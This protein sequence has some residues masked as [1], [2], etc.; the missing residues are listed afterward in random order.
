[1]VS[2]EA[3]ISLLSYLSPCITLSFLSFLLFNPVFVSLSFFH[4]QSLVF[5][6]CCCCC[7]LS[8]SLCFF[9]LSHSHI[10][11]LP[12]PPP[13]AHF[14]HPPIS[15]FFSLFLVE[16]TGRQRQKQAVPGRNVDRRLCR[17]DVWKVN[18]HRHLNPLNQHL[19]VLS[20]FSLQLPSCC[21]FSTV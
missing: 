7:R 21:W 14:L 6:C 11:P 20:F 1:M 15:S 4:F 19:L 8:L 13:L 12:P 3:S 2:G 17:S 5:M 10:L 9:S 18:W 16:R